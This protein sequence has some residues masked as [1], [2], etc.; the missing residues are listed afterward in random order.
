M[1]S[2]EIPLFPEQAS[3]VAAEVD[4]LYLFTVGLSLFFSVLIFGLVIYL[5]YRF[6]R[7]SPNERGTYTKS[8]A[9]EV[10]WTVIPLCILMFLFFWGTKVFY[11]L[12]RP[13]ADAAE[14]YVVGKQWMWKV[15]HPEGN[16]EI[17]DLHV[18]LGRPIKL[19][20]T[21]ED[22]IHSYFIPAF[23]V[24]ADVL[25]GRYTTVWFEATKPGVY[26]I[27]C[28][29]YCGVEHSQMIGKVY[30]ME[31]AEYEA[32]LD[33]RQ[34]GRP[35]TASGEELFTNLAC[36]TCHRG[37][38][39]ARGPVLAGLDG[40]EVLLR[41]GRT[42]TRD[43]NYLRQAILNPEAHL[44]DGY[45][46]LMPSYQGQITEEQL[47]QLIRYLKE[48]DQTGGADAQSQADAVD[49]G[50]APQSEAAESTTSGA[51]AAH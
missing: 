19:T 51:G 40:G 14:F 16:R 45:D 26:H 35:M 2:Y 48:I 46:P 8:V 9:L 18:P 28:A 50:V 7:K 10:V 15:Q 6:R 33:G 29:E 32:W 27:F 25:P 30:V 13:P 31:P 20:M 43:D 11:T 44:V 21:S 38:D 34:L 39:T 1:S 5:G 37:D 22:V 47:M 42:V 41:G 4:A 12:S 17:N 3:T 49:Q 36:I 23:R 24:K